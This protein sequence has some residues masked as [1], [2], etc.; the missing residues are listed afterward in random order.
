MGTDGNDYFRLLLMQDDADVSTDA[1]NV[2]ISN[3]QLEF[4][5]TATEFEY[6]TPADQ[7]ARCQ[8]YFER[9]SYASNTSILTAQCTGTTTC[10]GTLNYQHKRA[11]PAVS[12]SG[13]TI[14]VLDAAGALLASTSL[15]Y[16]NS[17][18][19]GLD[20]VRVQPVVASGLV[21]GN[22]SSLFTNSTID[23]DIDAE[24]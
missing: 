18:T 24:L 10:I 4:G 19:A 3:V 20:N 12:D 14:Q 2:D 15:T 17:T 11:I 21:A 22:A 1:W 13:G 8:R 9:R 5:D 7:L 6:V 23:I 16:A